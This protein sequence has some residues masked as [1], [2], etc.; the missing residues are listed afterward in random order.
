MSGPQS[1]WQ[2][3]LTFTVSEP[4]GKCL[5]F[6]LSLADIGGNVP[7]PASIAAH[8]RGKLHIRSNWKAGSACQGKVIGIQYLRTVVV[9]AD[10]ESF[11][12]SHDQSGL[13]VF[14]VLEQTN[15]ARSSLLPLS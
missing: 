15:I 14:F 5:S 10:F 2:E 7:Y 8:V 3:L 6:W 13:A 1:D 12:S 9:G 11:V 4:N